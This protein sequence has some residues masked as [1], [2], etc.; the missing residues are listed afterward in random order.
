MAT[1]LKLTNTTG[2]DVAID[3]VGI[4]IP[5]ASSDSITDPPLIRNLA[6]SQSLRNLVAAGTIT[7][8]DGTNPV[9]IMD[10]LVYWQGAGYAFP[11][12][13]DANIRWWMIQQNGGL[14]T[15]NNVGFTT[16]PTAT[17]TATVLNAPP[18]QFINYAS[19]AV[20]ASEAGWVSSAFSQTMYQFRPRY[21]S[22]MRTGGVI[23]NVRYWMGLFS[24][25]PATA[26]DPAIN[27]MGFRY[28]TVADGTAFWRCWSNDGAG[29]GTVTVTTVPFTVSTNYVL[30][31]EVSPDGLSIFFYIND[32]LVATHVTDLPG[33]AVNMGHVERIT[34]LDAVAKSVALSKVAVSQ[35]AA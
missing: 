5:A 23:T 22:I 12:E 17:G 2:A 26:D 20:A 3:D 11:S 13:I 32:L 19:A 29:G 34:T 16:A 10:L 4:I 15:L 9:T 25:T 35:R 7:M 28:S 21:K 1:T 24:A 33:A 6:T 14:T 8:S 30:S 18:A 31:I 27:G